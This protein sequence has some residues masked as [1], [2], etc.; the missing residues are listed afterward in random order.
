MAA[1]GGRG[2]WEAPGTLRGQ[3]RSLRVWGFL[4]GQQV[5]SQKLDGVQDRGPV[6]RRDREWGLGKWFGAFHVVTAAQH[7]REGSCLSPK[8]PG[9]GFLPQR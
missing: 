3:S 8:P 4:P 6:C 9:F 2:G 7:S 5:Q 1:A